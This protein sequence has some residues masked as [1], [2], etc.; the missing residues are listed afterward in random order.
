MLRGE[1]PIDDS[2]LE[3][4][5]SDIPSE[6]TL[7]IL[8]FAVDNKAEDLRRELSIEPPR[9]VL[10][11]EPGFEEFHRERKKGR[12]VVSEGT[13]QRHDL[14]SCKGLNITTHNN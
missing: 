14:F 7:E 1:T 4:I 13:I 11:W 2:R 10:R 9:V 6:E 5:L 3:K 8:G 12:K